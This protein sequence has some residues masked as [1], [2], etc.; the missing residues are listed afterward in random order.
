MIVTV[1]LLMKKK[2]PF[3]IP[4]AQRF[5]M[6]APIMVECRE[7]AEDY[8][9]RI[10]AYLEVKQI[11]I[12]ADRITV[13]GWTASKRET[14]LRVLMELISFSKEMIQVANEFPDT[15]NTVHYRKSLVRYFTHHS[16]T[17]PKFYD[18]MIWHHDIEPVDPE[19]YTIIQQKREEIVDLK[20]RLANVMW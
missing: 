3:K 14:L 5:I 18:H 19:L 9:D 10:E 12:P 17:M 20:N 4:T 15:D 7:Y 13:I 1:V 6:V 8:I 11:V 16:L 2:R